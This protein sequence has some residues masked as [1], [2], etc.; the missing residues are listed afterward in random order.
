MAVKAADP[1]FKVT[2]NRCVQLDLQDVTTTIFGFEMLCW[3]QTSVI[4]LIY[5]L[6]GFLDIWGHVAL[7]R[8]LRPVYDILLLQ[9][10]PGDLLGAYPHRQFH[11]L[12]GF[13]DSQAALSNSYPTTC[14]PNREAACR[15]YFFDDLWYDPTGPQT[16]DLPWD[17]ETDTR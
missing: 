13:L 16:S 8:N 10:I 11:T 2:S 7:N 4:K 5:P 9:L 17:L 15:Y 6:E 14:L 1:R 12:L 3:S